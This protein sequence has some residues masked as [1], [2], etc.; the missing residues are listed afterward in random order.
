MI[1]LPFPGWLIH[2]E[3]DRPTQIIPIAGLQSFLG[4]ST[5]Y[6]SAR[7]GKIMSKFCVL[8]QKLGARLSNSPT[9]PADWPWGWCWKEHPGISYRFDMSVRILV[10]LG[11]APRGV[12]AGF[13]RSGYV[14]TNAST[15]NST[16]ANVNNQHDR[17]ETAIF[18]SINPGKPSVKWVFSWWEQQ[19]RKRNCTENHPCKVLTCYGVIHSQ[20]E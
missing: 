20:A 6:D 3:S 14:L 12:R 2:C 10:G 15:R 13:T 11:L 4:L 5:Q 16:Y 18:T 7:R 19:V 9:F 1:G 17:A 8:V